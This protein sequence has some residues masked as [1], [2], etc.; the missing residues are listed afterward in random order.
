MLLAS[1]VGKDVIYK[2]Q[3]KKAVLLKASALWKKLRKWKSQYT[4]GENIYNIYI[5]QMTSILT[6]SPET[7]FM[8]KPLTLFKNENMF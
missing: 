4:M 6:T 5:W 2:L 1:E 7:K 3:K 8:V